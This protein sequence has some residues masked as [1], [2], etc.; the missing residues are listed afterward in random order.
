MNKSF[1]SSV[2]PKTDGVAR[3]YPSFQTGVLTLTKLTK[4]MASRPEL[5]LGLLSHPP[6]CFVIFKLV[7]V[8]SLVGD[9]CKI[10]TLFEDFIQFH[11]AIYL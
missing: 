8:S 3:F 1:A 10:S 5:K 4:D 2:V 6:F 11:L 7:R 9:F